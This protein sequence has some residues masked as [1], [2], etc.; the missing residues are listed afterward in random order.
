MGD[1]MLSPVVALFSFSWRVQGHSIGFSFWLNRAY[2]NKMTRDQFYGIIKSLKKILYE[3]GV[4]IA[5]TIAEKKQEKILRLLGAQGQMIDD[6]YG[7]GKA[8]GF[9]YWRL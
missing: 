3:A 1:T 2:R 7:P 5:F 4:K 9:F 8:G 6:F